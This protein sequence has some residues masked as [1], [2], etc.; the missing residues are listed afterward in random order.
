MADFTIIDIFLFVV[1]TFGIG[2]IIGITVAVFNDKGI[3]MIEITYENLVALI[4][5]RI[6]L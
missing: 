4:A 2:V 6:S 1:S 5:L 3:K